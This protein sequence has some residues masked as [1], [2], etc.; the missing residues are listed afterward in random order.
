MENS[1]RKK[2]KPSPKKWIFASK[3]TGFRRNPGLIPANAGLFH[4][5]GNNPVRYIDPDGRIIRI[6]KY[7]SQEQIAEYNEAIK[8]L[9][10]SRRGKELIQ[11]LEESPMIFTIEFNYSN[12]DA[13]DPESNVIKWDSNS[14]LETGSGD[15]QSAALGLIHEMGHAEQDLKGK[16]NPVFQI[17][18]KEEKKSAKLLLEEENLA[19][20]ENVVATQLNEPKRRSYLDY[21]GVKTMSNST[22]FV[23]TT[24]EAQKKFKYYYNLYAQKNK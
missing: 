3:R 5:A 14:G 4:Y 16:F 9:S 21:K 1:C 10:T 12:N 23:N 19:T 6:D 7:A 24:Y 20:T 11:K 13:Y 17:A 2:Y 8:Y 22:Q 15:I 18:N